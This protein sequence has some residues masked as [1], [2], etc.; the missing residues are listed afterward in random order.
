M[1]IY[2]GLGVCVVQ[3][4]LLFPYAFWDPELDLLA[5]CATEPEDRGLFFL[6]YAF[7]ERIAGKGAVLGALVSGGCT[8]AYACV[9]V[10]IYACR[11]KG[12]VLGALVSGQCSDL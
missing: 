8:H 5:H 7:H 1:C 12:P 4:V 11:A 10:Q 9:C 2:V 6:F 3:L